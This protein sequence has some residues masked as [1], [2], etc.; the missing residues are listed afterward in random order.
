MSRGQQSQIFQ[1]TSGQQGQAFGNAENSL[2][3][4]QTDVGDYQSQLGKYAAANPYGEGGEFQSAQNQVLANT[5]DASAQAAGAKLQGIAERTGQN[6]AGAISAT[7]AMQ[8]GNERSL[9]SQEAAANAER[10]G[11]GAQ[12]GKSVLQGY[13][14]VPGMEEGIAKGYSGLYGTALGEEEQAAKTPSFGDELGDAFAQNLGKG[15]SSLV[16]G[17]GA[18]G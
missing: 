3:L 8:Q 2:S 4:A 15:L 7:E 16:D 17:G 11:A 14:E 18:P 12:Y 5:A 6:P 13:G 10:L 1:T 9:A